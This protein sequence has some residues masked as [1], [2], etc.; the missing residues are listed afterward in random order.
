MKKY[1][2]FDH[3]A[4]ININIFNLIIRMLFVPLVLTNIVNS[5]VLIFKHEEKSEQIIK[6]VYVCVCAFILIDQYNNLIWIIKIT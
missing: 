2:S 4:T 6:C 3:M 1:F 5:I